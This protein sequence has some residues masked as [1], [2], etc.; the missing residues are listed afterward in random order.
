MSGGTKA[1]IIVVLI[2]LFLI[3]DHNSLHL[4]NHLGLLHGCGYGTHH[5][6]CK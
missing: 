4:F 2:V 5:Q 6:S 3:W 1:L